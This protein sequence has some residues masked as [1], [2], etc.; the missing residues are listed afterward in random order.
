M[1][2]SLEQLAKGHVALAL[3]RLEAEESWLAPMCR[4]DLRLPCAQLPANALGIDIDASLVESPEIVD[5]GLVIVTSELKERVVLSINLVKPLGQNE[6]AE[7][8]SPL[9][10][11]AN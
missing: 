10:R 9:V 3:L 6:P 8:P 4:A 1:R 11:I 7:C 2:D 5:E